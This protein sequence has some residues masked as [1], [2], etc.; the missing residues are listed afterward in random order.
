MILILNILLEKQKIYLSTEQKVFLEQCYESHFH[1]IVHDK[2]KLKYLIKE[3]VNQT[4]L[5]YK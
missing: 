4:K 5:S 1:T 3:I 2:N